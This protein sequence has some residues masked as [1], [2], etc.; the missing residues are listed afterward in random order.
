MNEISDT[1]KQRRLDEAAE[2]RRVT[3]RGVFVNVFLA[4]AKIA[5]GVFAGSHALLADGLH[6][7]SDL[8]TDAAILIGA[9]YWSEPADAAHPYGHGRYETLINIGIGCVLLFTGVG[10]AWRAGISIFRGADDSIH[11]EWLVLFVALLAVL[12]KEWLYR[13]TLAVAGKLRSRALESNAWHHRSDALSSIP[14]ALAVLCSWYFPRFRHF[15]DIAA[16][17]VSLMIVKV[18]LDIFKPSLGELLE[19]GDVKLYERVK[20]LAEDYEEIGEIHAVRSRRVG[21]AVL[22]DFHMLVNPDMSV[23]D[24]HVIAED[25]KERLL[26]LEVELSDAVIHIEP[27]PDKK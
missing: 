24:A 9:G 22:V 2:I 7:F 5:A 20:N 21:K 4:A 15:D 8:T 3:W 16:I 11:P 10:I 12:L 14:V 13:W 25:F 27:L 17:I 26:C 19:S 23:N 18:S 6:S 1:S